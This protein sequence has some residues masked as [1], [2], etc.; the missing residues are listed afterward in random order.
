MHGS[1]TRTEEQQFHD[2]IE[3]LKVVAIVIIKIN[4]ELCN[5]DK[6]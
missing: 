2:Y 3:I 1:N 5:I 4:Q 6:R